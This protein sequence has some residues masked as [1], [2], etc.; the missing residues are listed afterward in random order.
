M[1]PGIRSSPP[2]L[3]G[4]L[5][6]ATGLRLFRLGHQPLWIDE[7][8]S[9]QLATYVDGAP[10]W[11]GLLTDIHGP[12][13]SAI[14]HLWV[15]LGGVGETWL[16]LLY[17]LPSVAA[18]PVVYILARDLF[19]ERAGRIA[20]WVLALAPFH[21]WYAQEVRSYSW[22]L[23]WASI[24]LW[25]FVRIWDGRAGRG[26]WFALAGVLAL[27]VLTNFSVAFLL[28]ALSLLML[29]R[30]PFSARRLAAWGGVLVFVGLVFLPW[31]LDWYGRIG[32]ERMFTDAPPPMAVP[33]READGFSPVEVPYTAWSFAF[34]YSLGPSLRSLHL[35][36]S[37]GALARHLPVILA[38]AAT[39]AIALLGALPAIRLRR[40]G[41]LLGTLF[42]VPLLL[43]V[44]LAVR[45]IK[46]FHP[47]YLIVCFPLFVATLA[48]GWARPGRLLRTSAVAAI[49]LA[50]VS[51]GHHYFD[52]AYAKEDCRSAARL[53]QENEEP[54]DSVVVIYAFR[55]FQHYFA[56]VGDGKAE[57]HHVHKRFLR[58]D[59]EM[60]AHVA[61]SSESASRVWLVLTRWW[62]V[63]PEGRIRRIFEESLREQRRWEFPGVKV[64]LYEGSPA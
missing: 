42:A 19:D 37:L 15:Q 7:L 5:V 32:G 62:D 58:T 14:L 18:V 46:T 55:P 60:R 23:L 57:L 13:N 48:A 51:L 34:G 30:R 3:V 43:S 44:F 47:R 9:L 12:F 27:A 40:R 53:V 52:D 16:R 8:I 10:F 26:Q 45:G 49:A 50:L 64:T 22:T 21:V 29:L 36:R 63:A 33:L 31:F 61:D 25:L 39:V 4:C 56:D 59:D 24:A 11:R 2:W 28:I 6:A 1:I 17:V 20:A 54:G 35:D 38:G 41:L